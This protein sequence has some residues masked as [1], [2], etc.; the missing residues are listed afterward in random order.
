M[1]YHLSATKE[2]NILWVRLTGARTREAVW[3]ASREIVEACEREG[4]P[5]VLLDV[6]EFEG[7]LASL[8]DYELPAKRFPELRGI[9]RA[10]A[11]VD[12]PE[13]LDRFALFVDVAQSL[14]FNLRAF[15]DINRATKW[16]KRT[17]STARS[18]S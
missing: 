4:T 16:L 12:T 8:D 13:N 7:R 11:I 3:T 1:A 10:V 15:G 18:L 6:R 17:T 2:R 14:G 5:K 9:V